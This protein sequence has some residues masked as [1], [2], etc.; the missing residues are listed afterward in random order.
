LV[1]SLLQADEKAFLWLNGWVGRL[2]W[3]DGF[4]QWVDSDYLVP[5]AL[6]L[7]LLGLWFTGST[8]KARERNQWAV[9]TAILGLA[10]ANLSVE[11][12]NHYLFRPR[13]FVD[14]PVSLLFYRPVDSSFPAN[15]AVVGF[16]VATGVWC[17]N[18][19]VGG[20]LFI[21][22]TVFAL[23]RVYAGVFYPLDIIGGAALGAIVA[24]LTKRLLQWLDPLPSK[25][26][27]MARTLYLA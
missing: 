18:R 16:A 19:K 11:I 1:E 2:P 4:V 14:L 27:Q 23:S 13:P 3:L 15:P 26:I 17:W 8:R 12:L 24:L 21:V 9:M 22:A 6:S 5:V 20:V 7:V 10:L 25:I